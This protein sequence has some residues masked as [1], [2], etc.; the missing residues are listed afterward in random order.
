MR[1]IRIIIL[2]AVF[3]GFFGSAILQA[4][5]DHST[6]GFFR[7]VRLSRL[8]VDVPKVGRRTFSVTSETRVSRAGIALDVNRIPLHSVV[9]VVER[10]G[11][12]IMVIVEEVPK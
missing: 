4:Y 6:I 9:R 8:Q 3:S 12:A 11:M 7:G 10:D 2:S 5:E 1:Y